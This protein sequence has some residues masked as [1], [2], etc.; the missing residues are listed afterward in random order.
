MITLYKY[1][2][3]VKEISDYANIVPSG[4]K[5]GDGVVSMKII[6]AVR[7]KIK[8]RSYAG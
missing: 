7:V 6:R 5:A 2:L 1:K 8:R 4:R 3:D